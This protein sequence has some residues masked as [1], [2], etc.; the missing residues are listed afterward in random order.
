VV[1]DIHLGNGIPPS[2]TYKNL[3][4]NFLKPTQEFQ[5]NIICIAGDLTDRR[6]T[7]NSEAA[8]YLNKFI[9]E[10]KKFDAIILYVM[11]TNSH[12][13][14]NLNFFDSEID[15]R[16]RIYRSV[17]IDE[18]C[19]I[20]FLFIPEEHVTNPKEYYEN[21]FDAKTEICIGHGLFDYVY[22]LQKQAGGRKLTCPVFSEDDFRNV[23]GPVI[24]G[25]VHTPQSKDKRR[26]VGSFGRYNHSEEENK[27]HLEIIYDTLG[28]AVVSDKFIVNTGA[29]RFDTIL[30]S[31]LPADRDMMIS[32]L[33]DLVQKVYRLRIR[34]DR[35]IDDVRMS[36]I[37]SFAKSQYTVTVDKHFAKKNKGVQND[38][39]ELM[40]NKYESLSPV[41]AISEFILERHNIH[42]DKDFILHNIREAV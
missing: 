32:V 12:E 8:L 39:V 6:L 36:D 30:E 7:L 23:K 9:R 20:R 11:G 34:L 33:T 4:E 42:M 17:T 29:L 35:K 26:Y 3:E 15:D 24:F 13:A 16:F 1:A 19:G 22:F 41:D 37:I 31:N 18:V 21:Y 28:D 27:G 14:G 2:L 10:L 25:H 5:P 40:E 38:E